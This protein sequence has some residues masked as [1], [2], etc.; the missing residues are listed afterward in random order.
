MISDYLEKKDIYVFYIHPFEL[1]NLPPPQMPKATPYLTK[2]RFTYGRAK[3]VE[4][5]KMLI[6]LLY[7]KEYEFTTFSALQEDLT[8]SVIS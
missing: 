7:S 5:L 4:R 2:F 1:S 8:R 3:V 6:D